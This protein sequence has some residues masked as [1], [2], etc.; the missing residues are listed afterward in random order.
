MRIRIAE[1]KDI[2]KIQNVAEHTFP[3]TYKGIVSDEQISFMMDMMYSTDSLNRQMDAEQN[4]FILAEEDDGRTVGYV[5][6]RPDGENLYHLEKLYVLPEKQGCGVG[7]T[8]IQSAFSKARQFN[9]NPCRVQLNVQR[10]N[11]AKLFYERM[12]MKAVDTLDETFG[13]GFERKDYIMEIK[14]S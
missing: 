6:I 9:G 8:L 12:G 13:D 10:D 5:S 3:V 2:K 4:T 14:V 11:K 1:K 7:R